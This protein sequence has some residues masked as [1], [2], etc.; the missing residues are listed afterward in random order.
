MSF[1]NPKDFIITRKRKLY[2]FALFNNS[3]IC[4]EFNDW[5]PERTE[6]DNLEIGAGTGLFSECLALKNPNKK[7]VAIDVKADRLVKGAQQAESDQL[8]NIRFLRA[9]ADQLLEAF[10]PHSIK[11]IWITFP[12]PY[13]KKRNA[14]RRL[15]HPTFLKI[16]KELL[17]EDGALYF[18]TDAKELFDWSLEQLVAEGWQIQRLS[19]DL[20][21]SDLNE[22]YKVMTTYERRFVSEGLKINFVKALPPKK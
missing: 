10:A 11:Y 8:R 1:L 7:F 21:E 15:T 3:S 4:F 19:F 12:D 14:G 20:H 13:P 9:R 5:N 2:K 16:Y 6:V 17:R 22:N 18:K